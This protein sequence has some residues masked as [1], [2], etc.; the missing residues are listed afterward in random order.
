M[1]PDIASTATA[2]V[3]STT[4]VSLAA[5]LSHWLGPQYGPYAA[6]LFAAMAGAI[7]GVSAIPTVTRLEGAGRFIRFT[8]TAVVL[9]G[10]GT[11]L[12][13]G[14]LDTT[15]ESPVELS[16]LVAFG[17]AAV[18]DRWTEILSRLNPVGLFR[19]RG[20]DQ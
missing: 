14:Y 10:G 17:I 9:V 7:W 5:V 1:T 13:A 19:P 3:T 2:V 20:K 12:A 6:I 16:I 15:F 4:S 11:A 18:G 8:I